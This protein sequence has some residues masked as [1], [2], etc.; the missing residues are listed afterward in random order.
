MLNKILSSR[1]H[2]IGKYNL[3]VS[4]TESTEYLY[5]FFVSGDTELEIPGN[6]QVL[7]KMLPEDERLMRVDPTHQDVY[8]NDIT[9]HENGLVRNGFLA[10]DTFLNIKN[11]FK[12]EFCKYQKM[13][14]YREPYSIEFFENGRISSGYLAKDTK[15]NIEGKEYVFKKHTHMHFTGNGEV[16]SGYLTEGHRALVGREK[17]EVKIRGFIFWND[18]RLIT[19]YYLQEP[20]EFTVNNKKVVFEN[21]IIL[22]PSGN[23]VDGW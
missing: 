7:F 16:R 20:V 5:A 2:L 10:E 6:G 22:D 14:H 17:T 13:P 21:N 8:F 1:D 15:L 4:E 11:G 3:K 19:R 12:I 18:Q 23:V 9:F